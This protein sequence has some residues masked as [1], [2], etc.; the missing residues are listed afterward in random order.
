MGTFHATLAEHYN[1][2]R[3]VLLKVR[4]SGLK[5]NKNKCQFRKESIVILGHIISLEGIRFDRSK[6][7]AITKIHVPQS[8]NELQRSLG[9]VS[10]FYKFIEILLK[11]PQQSE[12]F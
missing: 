6:A 7:D 5:F 11:L 1:D 8:L 2:L 12:R 10:H 4:E 9:I 3:K